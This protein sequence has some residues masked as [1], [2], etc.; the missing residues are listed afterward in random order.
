MSDHRIE[1][2]DR[3]IGHCQWNAADSKI[4]KRRNNA[5]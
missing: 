4:E 1:S 2:I 3:F 5:I